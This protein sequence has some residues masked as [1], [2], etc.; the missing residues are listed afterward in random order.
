VSVNKYRLLYWC[1]P[2]ADLQEV[3][4]RFIVNK[5]TLEIT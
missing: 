3:A 1:I 5:Q 2:L 4:V